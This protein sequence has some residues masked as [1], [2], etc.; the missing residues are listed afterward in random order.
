MKAVILAGGLGTRM[1]DLTKDTPKPMLTI[2]GKN[3]IEHKIDI[4]DERFDEVV[5]VVGYLKDKIISHFGSEFKGKKITYIEQDVLNGTGGALWLCKDL[6]KDKF[7]VMMGDDIYAKECVEEACKY[8]WA[9]VARERKDSS[10]IGRIDV[11]SEGKLMG[12]IE[13]DVSKTGLVN[14]GLYVLQS[15]I[16]NYPLVKLKG[17]EEFGLP[18]T[19]V[20]AVNDY[21]IKVVTCDKWHQVTAPEDLINPV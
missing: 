21:D 8:E 2:G 3:L 6:L 10:P 1:R 20:Q 11:N 5:I 13:G 15:D 16:F 17:K 9:L 7:L 14:T 12:V 18:Q 4:L 19:I